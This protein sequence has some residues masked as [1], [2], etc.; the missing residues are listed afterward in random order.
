LGEGKK[1]AIFFGREEGKGE[2]RG[3]EKGGKSNTSSI[4]LS[5]K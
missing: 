4:P 2:M 3:K 1:K 5:F